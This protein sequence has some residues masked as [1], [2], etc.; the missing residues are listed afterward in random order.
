[1]KPL[2]LLVVGGVAGGA[3]FAARARRLCEDA[4]ITVIER[5]PDVSF[6][7]CGLPYHI[8]GEIATRDV[9]AVQTPASLNDLLK[10][11][12]RTHCEAIDI[13]RRGLRLQVRN[14][15][16]GEC[17]WLPYDKLML[18]PGASPLRPPLPGIDDPRIFTLRNLQDM[19]RIIAAADAGM[20]AV[21]IGAG[22]IGLEMAEQL[23]RRGMKVQLV[24]LMPQVIPPLDAPMTALLDSELRRNGVEVFLGDGI[25][26]FRPGD[27]H[28]GCELNSGAV[29]DADLV[30]LSIGVKPDS[31]LARKAGLELGARGHIVVDAFQRTSDANIYAAGDV[32]ETQD[33][34]VPGRTAV[35]MGGP[36]N[37]QGR[38]AADHIFLGDK[39]R[40]YPGSIGTG[41]VRAFDV[42]AGITGWSEKRLRA[43]QY[44]FASVTV[45]DSHHASYYPG[46]K[47][48]TL[49]IVWDARTGRL[50]GAQ[51]TGFE[52][53]D[54]RLDVLSTAIAAHM[55]VEDLCHLELAY[56]PPFGS[57]KDII[58]LAGFAA[59][60]R[61]DG[62]VKH[63]ETLPTDPAVQI[64][65]VRG[66]PLADAYPAPATVLNIP[67]AT[68]RANLGK[69]DKNRPVVTLCAFGKM[70]Y[71]AARVLAQNGFDVSSFSGGLKAN[72]D[73][74]SP[75]KLP[76]A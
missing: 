65:D 57:A 51:A 2:K 28:V 9:L 64:V 72:V 37:R 18:S 31:D 8:G 14:T 42:V 6:A 62:L 58:N 48:M 49:K 4:E 47:P 19:D 12:V 41:I 16:T 74:R 55:T 39:A 26:A 52:G 53:I 54:K 7:N 17:E 23:Q 73:P 25:R 35:P 30:I 20:R 10:L 29:L 15:A 21:I 63:T 61:R 50:L 75:G 1:M 59:C 34:V 60:N 71:F 44:P 46:A 36:A 45:N 22:F 27:S 24:E 68:L 67:F 11:D 56:A 5:G 3:S 40:P 70:S 38:V 33:R 76:T 13:D 32:V 66:K 43:L 69:L